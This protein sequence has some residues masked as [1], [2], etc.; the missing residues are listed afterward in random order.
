[1]IASSCPTIAGFDASWRYSLLCRPAYAKSPLAHLAV[2]GCRRRWRAEI[3]RRPHRLPQLRR[4]SQQGQGHVRGGDPT[5]RWDC[6]CYLSVPLLLSLSAEPC[7]GLCPHI[8]DL[9]MRLH[10]HSCRHERRRRHHRHTAFCRAVVGRSPEEH[11]A[12]I[13]T[14]M[15][16]WRAIWHPGHKRAGEMASRFPL[17]SHH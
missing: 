4:Q 11:L 5:G 14:R 8:L 10:Q 16:G 13:R 3:V 17:G 1:M 7:A 12:R 2:C 9:I 15:G 6:R